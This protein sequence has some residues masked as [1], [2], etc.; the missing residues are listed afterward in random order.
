VG[1]GNQQCTVHQ[2]LALLILIEGEGTHGSV[3]AAVGLVELNQ[4]PV[5][6]LGPNPIATEVQEDRG[7]Y[8]RRGETA[9]VSADG[10]DR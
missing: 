10:A 3:V 8:A 6:A 4:I 1:A 9:I 2:Y 7:L 5:V